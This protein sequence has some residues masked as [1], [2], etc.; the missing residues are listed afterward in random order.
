MLVQLLQLLLL[1]LILIDII[2]G[3]TGADI[4]TGNVGADIIDAGTGA[5]V[6]AS[7][8]GIDAIILDGGSDDAAIDT[9]KLG[10]NELASTDTTATAGSVA[11][12]T[13]VRFIQGAGDDIIDISIAGIESLGGVE[14]LV[15]TTNATVT[16]GTTTA[17]EDGGA[18]ID[19]VGSAATF[20]H[21]LT[22]H[23]T[24]L[25]HALTEAGVKADLVVG[26]GNALT[27]TNAL[28]DGD[29]FLMLID[30]GTDAALFLI[31]A[32]GAAS[33]TVAASEIDVIKLMTL[34]GEGAISSDI[35]ADN[36]SLSA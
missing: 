1:M 21:A 22:I 30:N 26:G 15:L 10:A 17:I 16:T 14:D 13:V 2:T 35:H 19:T 7:G 24:T 3:G 34:T 9:I 29:A 20:V 6:I 8:G 12:D 4:I 18:V 33:S 25:T 27:L 32:T 23:D 36:F 31:V 28:T 5:D 11:V